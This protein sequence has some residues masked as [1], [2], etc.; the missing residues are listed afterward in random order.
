MKKGQS[1]LGIMSMILLLIFMFC[2]FVIMAS[3]FQYKGDIKDCENYNSYGYYTEVVGDFWDVFNGQ[4]IC[5][6]VMED[7]TRLPLTDYKTMTIK[8]ALVR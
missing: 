3:F 6:I 2:V 1:L 8:N 7:G 4:N 5:L